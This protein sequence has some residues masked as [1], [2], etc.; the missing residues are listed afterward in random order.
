MKSSLSA[1]S[2]IGG[3]ARVTWNAVANAASYT[4]TLSHGEED[5]Y[6][7]RTADTSFAVTAE[8]QTGGP[9]R[10][11]SVGVAAENSTGISGTASVTLKDALPPTATG[12][13]VS[14]FQNGATFDLT[15]RAITP[16]PPSDVTGY[17][18]AKG[19]TADFGVRQLSE[20]RQAAGL[21]FTWA[22][23]AQGRHYFRVALRD[24]FYEIV[25]DPL[26]LNWSNVFAVDAEPVPGTDEEVEEGRNG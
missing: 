8:M 11:L 1:S 14:I 9:F 19:E 2:Y 17:L 18:I 21:P 6:I 20:V 10:E 16:A 24:A 26:T 3:E 13:D 15:L 22:G 4:V 25:R 12:A 7:A 23:L 5:L